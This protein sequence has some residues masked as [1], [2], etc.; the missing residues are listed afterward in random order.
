LVIVHLSQES[1]GIVELIVCDQPF[2]R[3][4]AIS[5]K[6]GNVSTNP[7]ATSVPSIC[8]PAGFSTITIRDNKVGATPYDLSHRIIETKDIGRQKRGRAILPSVAVFGG[9]EWGIHI[10]Q[11]VLGHAV[12]GFLEVPCYETRFQ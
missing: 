7:N 9:C 12:D 3:M 2:E 8:Q 10:Y 5:R 1:L 6:S 11:V 4:T